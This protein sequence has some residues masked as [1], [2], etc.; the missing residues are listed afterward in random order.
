MKANGAIKIEK[1]IPLPSLKWAKPSPMVDAMK[2]MKDGDSFLVPIT[3]RP[4]LSFSAKK[5]GIVIATR[6]VDA[7]HVRCWR[8]KERPLGQ[9]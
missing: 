5:A 2:K 8:I 3:Q 9:R 6:T 4:S 7:A 1:G